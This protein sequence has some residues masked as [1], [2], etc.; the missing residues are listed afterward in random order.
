MAISPE[1]KTGS[2]GERNDSD[3]PKTKQEK[4]K[5]ELIEKVHVAKNIVSGT[6]ETAVDDLI[7]GAIEIAYVV[8][9]LTH[10]QALASAFIVYLCT[11]L[12]DVLVISNDDAQKPNKK[13]IKWFKIL[14]ISVCLY[15]T[16][17]WLFS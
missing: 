11:L 16:G 13:K 9:D 1:P 10:K 15:F 3:D 2:G 4:T 12:E 6:R 14:W 8:F 7:W 17:K 5:E